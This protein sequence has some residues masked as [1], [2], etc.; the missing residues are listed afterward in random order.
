MK[1]QSNFTFTPAQ[2]L[3]VLK[4][5]KRFFPW[6]I[7]LFVPLLLVLFI[8]VSDTVK[9]DI[10]EKHT[11]QVL[12]E[13]NVI[14]TYTDFKTNQAK[15]ESKISDNHGK[16]NFE[17]NHRLLFQYLFAEKKYSTNQFSA[18]AEKPNYKPDSILNF[19]TGELNKTKESVKL[20]PELIQAIVKPEEPQKPKEGCRA[21]FTG[22]VVGGKFL[23]M[24]ISQVYK[25][26]NY[27]EYVGAGE[28]PDNEKAFPKAVASTF[29]GIA[30][31]AGTRVVIYEGKDFK[32]KVLLDKTGPAIINNVKWKDD[33][34]YSHC[35]TDTYPEPLQTNFPQNVRFWSES[36]MQKWSFGSLKVICNNR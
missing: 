14:L 25:E 20:H 35:N 19:T 11:Q 26:D 4:F 1:S 27:S 5:K 23:D 15:T 30:I 13:A 32:G 3:Y 28:Y 22:L 12:P 9:F 36:D 29:D 7:L 8:P 17:V 2:D 16:V 24:H 33:P 18:R 31:D 34:R 21:F 6:W 10:T